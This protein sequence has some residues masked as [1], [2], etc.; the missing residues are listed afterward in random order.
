MIIITGGAGYVG[1]ALVPTVADSLEGVVVLDNMSSINSKPTHGD[2]RFCDVTRDRLDFTGA[3]CVIH[4][5]ANPSVMNSVENPAADAES[6]QG[7]IRVAEAALRAGCRIIFASSCAVYGDCHWATIDTPLRPVSPY[8]ISKATC[9]SY[10]R[11]FSERGLRVSVLRFGNIFGG[12]DQRGV[13]PQFKA[14]KAAGRKAVVFGDGSAV[15]SYVAI[16]NAVSAIWRERFE[17]PC[18]AWRV[19]NVAGVPMTVNQIAETIGVDVVHEPKRVGEA[20]FCVLGA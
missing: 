12:D 17:K 19:R 5:A 8:G 18:D 10:L 6:I 11:W 2:C 14:A 4:L 9:E 3:E 13:W 1:R 7:T 20:E 15:R 16:D